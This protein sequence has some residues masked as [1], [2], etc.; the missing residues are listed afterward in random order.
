MC[1]SRVD[2]QQRESGRKWAKRYVRGRR[3]DADSWCG[4]LCGRAGEDLG[5]DG[6]GRPWWNMIL[7]RMYGQTDGLCR[8]ARRC[9]GSFKGEGC[10]KKTRRPMSPVAPQSPEETRL[11]S[12]Q[13]RTRDQDRKCGLKTAI[14]GR[15][16]N[17]FEQQLEL[18]GRKQPQYLARKK[19]ASTP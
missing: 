8:H 16:T 5:R 11:N 18:L 12:S 9:R 7:F 1:K 10:P 6:F 3:A 4:S 14:G 15:T 2:T 13:A 17:F 19:K